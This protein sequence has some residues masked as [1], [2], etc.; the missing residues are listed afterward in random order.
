MVGGEAEAA[1]CAV[2]GNSEPEPGYRSP[3][4]AY[5]AVHE[6]MQQARERRYTA[7]V[8]DNLP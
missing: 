4:C 8:R 2:E 5:W 6:S 3:D 1:L 7:K